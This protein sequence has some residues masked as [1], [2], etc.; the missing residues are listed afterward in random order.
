[1]RAVIFQNIKQNKMK[2]NFREHKSSSIKTVLKKIFFVISIFAS[3]LLQKTF[4]QD[5]QS[6]LSQLLTSYYSI[7]DALVAGNANTASASATEFLKT[8]SSIDNKIIVQDKLNAMQ[9]DAGAI[10]QMKDIKH[11]RG[12]FADLSANMLALVKAAKFSSLPVYALYCPMKK[13]YWLSS[14]KTVKNPYFGSAMLTCG[15]VAETLNQ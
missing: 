15:S 5:S 14:D 6:Q 3:S 10:S 2:L 1:M 9:K 8:A 11:Q 12:H 7:K 13:S 4:A